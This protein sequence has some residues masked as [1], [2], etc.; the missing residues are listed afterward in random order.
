MHKQGYTLICS[1]LA[2]ISQSE[3]CFCM[4]L[5]VDETGIAGNGGQNDQKYNQ[6]QVASV[7]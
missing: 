6:H 4:E 1:A 5:P 2:H 7:V 3:L